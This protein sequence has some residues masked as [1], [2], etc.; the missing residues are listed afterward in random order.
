MTPTLMLVCFEEKL[1]N[2]RNKNGLSFTGRK[3]VLRFVQLASICEEGI[4]QTELACD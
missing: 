3:D 4:E 2:E 1:I